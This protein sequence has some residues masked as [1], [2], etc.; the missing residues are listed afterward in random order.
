MLIFAHNV[1]PIRHLDKS[2]WYEFVRTT[3]SAKFKQFSACV[4]GCRCTRRQDRCPGTLLHWP[5]LYWQMDVRNS[6]GNLAIIMFQTGKHDGKYL[7]CLAC[8]TASL[9]SIYKQPNG[10]SSNPKALSS[11]ATKLH[12]KI[13]FVSVDSETTGVSIDAMTEKFGNL[14]LVDEK[15]MQTNWSHQ[16]DCSSEQSQLLFV[17]Y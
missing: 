2:L 3:V 14:P 16:I 6:R 12:Q 5:S 1:I 8:P 10:V 9:R 13:S 4:C 11:I 7:M 15:S 17:M